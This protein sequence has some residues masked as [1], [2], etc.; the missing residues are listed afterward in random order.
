VLWT[1]SG[2]GQIVGR[3]M[4]WAR[5]IDT[6]L[7][8][9]PRGPERG[10]DPGDPNP[11]T[12]R[13][14]YGSV[15][16]TAWGSAT[17]DGI[18]ER[19]LGAHVLWL[20][21]SDY[22]PRDPRLPAVTVA[23]WAQYVLDCFD[24]VDAFVR[25]MQE[26]PFQVRPQHEAGAGES[27]TA[28][29]AIEDAAG[30]SAVIEYVAGEPVVH[31]GPETRVATNSPAFD[32]QVERLR[33]YEGFGGQNPLPGTTDPADRFV[34]A[35]Y[36]AQRLPKADSPEQAYAELLSVLRNAAQPFG[37]SDPQRPDVAVTLW[38]SLA[39]L[40]R[41]IYGFEFSLRPEPVWV[42]L[43]ALNLDRYEQLDLAGPELHGEVSARF[44]PAAEFIFP[45]F[46]G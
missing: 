14:R 19:G 24:T 8:V 13:A 18:N 16:A 30:D 22:G 28:N 23:T 43:D 44:E 25:A 32:Q 42:H 7:W 3:N 26:H 33:G 29:L 27:S 46:E 10:G 35:T 41:G 36:Y 15:V 2:Q 17:V 1:D 45:S 31:R 5:E 6:A 12:W 9:M 4:D 11:L 34:R 20:S 37:T 38:R 21:A 39:D 40:S